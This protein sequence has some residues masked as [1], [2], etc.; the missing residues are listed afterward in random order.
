MEKAQKGFMK[1]VNGVRPG[2]NPDAFL[3]I[4][5]LIVSFIDEYAYTMLISFKQAGVATTKPS[6][7]QVIRSRILGLPNCANPNTVGN[8][9]LLILEGVWAWTEMEG[10]V[11]RWP[12]LREACRRITGI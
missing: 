1:L 7:R 3:V 2:R 10:R 11:A 8:D 6:H 5:M 9:S 4:P 12:D